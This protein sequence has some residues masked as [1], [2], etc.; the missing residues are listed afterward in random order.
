MTD[1]SDFQVGE[2]WNERKINKPVKSQ[3]SKRQRKEVLEWLE[4]LRNKYP[5]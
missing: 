1:E 2:G 3:D 4:E 5:R